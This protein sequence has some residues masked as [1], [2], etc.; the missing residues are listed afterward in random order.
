MCP[1]HR[2]KDLH[3]HLNDAGVAGLRLKFGLQCGVDLVRLD[4]CA[5]MHV[6]LYDCERIPLVGMRLDAQP[7]RHHRVVDQD[8]PELVQ[9]AVS[10]VFV[11]E[12]VEHLLDCEVLLAVLAESLAGLFQSPLLVVAQR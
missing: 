6:Q 11:V 2:T 5:A 4:G 8:V 3:Q 7:D 1:S 10:E 12:I 9:M